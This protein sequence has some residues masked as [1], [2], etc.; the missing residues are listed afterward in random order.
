MTALSRAPYHPPALEPREFVVLL[1]NVTYAM[2]NATLTGDPAPVTREAYER[3]TDPRPGDLVVEISSRGHR[4][5]PQSSAVGRLLFVAGVKPRTEDE[6]LE[7]QAAGRWR[8]DRAHFGGPYWY[9]D[10]LDGAQRA[11]WSNCQ[12]IAMPQAS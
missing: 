7:A 6:W 3:M 5:W 2:Y 4:G 1:A 8:T 10:P 12:F 11:C 9:V